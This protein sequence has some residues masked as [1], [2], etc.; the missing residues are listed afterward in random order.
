MSFKVNKGV[1][2][3]GQFFPPGSE[4]DAVPK[5]AEAWLIECGAI[6]PLEQVEA[7]PAAKK[8]GGK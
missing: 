1:T 4:L 2:I 5:G 7:K 3:G 8:K 6:E